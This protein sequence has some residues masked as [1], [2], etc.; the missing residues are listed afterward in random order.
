MRCSSGC[1]K[2]TLHSHL[3]GSS[4]AHAPLIAP[5]AGGRAQLAG[6]G[7]GA[8]GCR[9]AVVF[10][11]ARCCRVKKCKGALDRDK[12]GS[13]LGWRHFDTSHHACCHKPAGRVP[14]GGLFTQQVAPPYQLT[15]VCLLAPRSDGVR[16][17]IS[18]ILV[19]DPEKRPTE[20]VSQA[21]GCTAGCSSCGTR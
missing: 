15:L 1:C 20:G 21:Q 19:A 9:A 8:A 16:D 7:H 4:G 10:G 2:L 6:S 3:T 13:E 17:L 5:G 18:R 11:V 14:G 12:A